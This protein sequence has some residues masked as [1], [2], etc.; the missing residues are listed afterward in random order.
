MI[1]LSELSLEEL[2]NLEHDIWDERER[3]ELQESL[4]P[5]EF[6][7]M[8][9]ECIANEWYYPK[10]F[11][12]DCKPIS[13]DRLVEDDPYITDFTV[14][15][16]WDYA[17]KNFF[18]EEFLDGYF[19]LDLPFKNYNSADGWYVCME[20]YE[21]AKQMLEK[22]GFEHKPGLLHELEKL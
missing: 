18:S 5:D 17:A 9:D 13:E 15:S 8:R 20:D 16:K 22:K 6:K 11:Y 3:R 1:N 7:K 12:F 4:V 14:I 2:L 19:R 21:T 10:Y